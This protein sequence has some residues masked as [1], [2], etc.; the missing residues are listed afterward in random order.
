MKSS[1]TYQPIRCRNAPQNPSILQDGFQTPKGLLWI[2]RDQEQVD[3]FGVDVITIQRGRFPERFLQFILNF[4]KE[5]LI[6]QRLAPEL[7]YKLV[8]HLRIVGLTPELP[9]REAGSA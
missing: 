4:R 9:T 3:L 2:R 8:I 7:N 5:I 6:V 1:A